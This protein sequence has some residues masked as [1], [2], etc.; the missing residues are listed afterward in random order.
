VGEPT[1]VH[2]GLTAFYTGNWYAALSKNDGNSW[3]YI[4]PY[5]KFP[6]VDN[7][8]CCDQYTMYVPNRRITVWLLQYSYSSTTKNGSYRIAIAKNETNLKAGVFHYYTF[9]PR[10]FGMPAGYWMDFPHMA[11]SNGNLFVT[12]N[13]FSAAKAYHSTVCWRMPLSELAA[14]TTVHY[15]Y[16]RQAGRTWRLTFGGTT[17]MYWWQHR[18]SSSGYLYRWADSS[19]SFQKYTINIASWNW[20]TKG[21]MIAKGPKG[22]NWMK[23]SDSRPLGGWVARGRIGF[24]W[25]A[26]QGG[27]F[28][29]P[30]TRVI[31]I[32][33]ATRALIRQSSIWSSTIA[34]AYPSASHNSRGHTGGTISYGGKTT[35]P[36]TAAWIVDDLDTRFAPLK[37]VAVAVGNN[38][39]AGQVWGDYLSS[40]P[41][42]RFTN[43]WVG[44]AMSTRGGTANSNQIPRYVHFGR[45]RDVVFRPD[46]RPVSLTSSST[47]LVHGS[48][49]SLTTKIENVGLSSAPT[50]TNG[51][52]LSTNS[53]ISTGDLLV[54]SFVLAPIGVGGSRT[55]SSSVRI[56]TNAPTGTCWL[57]VYADR[58]HSI[59]EGSETNNT[60]A[61]QVKCIGKPDLIVS[62]MSTSTTTLQAGGLAKVSFTVKNAGTGTSSSTIT[63]ILLSTNS[64]ITT[65]D[66]YLGGSFEA[67]LVKGASRSHSF[68]VRIP[69]ATPTST[70]YLGA[71][72]DVGFSLSELNELN[73]GRAAPA[74]RSL[75]YT[76]SLRLLE[77]RRIAYLNS[78]QKTGAYNLTSARLDASN[79]GSAPMALVAPRYQNYWYLLLMSG[80]SSFKFDAFT[81]LGLGILNTPILPLWLS[82]IPSGGIANP[83]FNL[84]KT[85][86]SIPFTMYVHS[87]WFDPSFKNIVG[88]GNNRLYL[89]IE[90]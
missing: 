62:A 36:S 51:L 82:R 85:T 87:F 29:Y 46:F 32:N 78:S 33:E 23:R 27:S 35:Y 40:I 67:S 88:L 54:R 13:I 10:N 14:G 79:G 64:L 37:A 61:K 42:S 31:E 24:M 12:A 55:Y 48:T 71:Y 86:I 6:K 70:R 38:S 59:L 20:G 75:K 19:N 49:Y 90:K 76:G 73:N 41:H 4:N 65:F 45:S 52:Y 69:W 60:M 80:S 66:T 58:T 2:H 1:A 18:N 8:F 5:T 68:F 3:S 11:Y 81:S 7:G 84:P 53:I 50:S 22:R 72:A 39:P 63:G 28:P 30:Y 25:N 47:T 89:R 17:T 57:G 83:G 9:N 16:I 44:S 43:T 56:P 34:W 77:Y 74:R 26:K 21:T 15:R